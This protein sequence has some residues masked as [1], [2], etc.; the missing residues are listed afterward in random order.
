MNIFN[1]IK[2]YY[3]LKAERLNVKVPLVLNKRLKRKYGNCKAIL[4]RINGQSK[5]TP[6][7]VE[8]SE[9]ALK[10]NWQDLID[11]INH[12]LAHVIVYRD[13]GVHTHVTPEWENTAIALNAKV[14]SSL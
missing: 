13:Y 8:I 11:T 3:S 9:S 6:I 1:I 4:I 2:V 14:R 7:L 12:E 10:L 5:T